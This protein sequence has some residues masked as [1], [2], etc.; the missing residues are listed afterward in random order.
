MLQCGYIDPDNGQGMGWT[1]VC[2][3]WGCNKA[4]LEV[5]PHR[6][7]PAGLWTCP[8]CHASYGD[9]A[10]VGPRCEEPAE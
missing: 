7:F 1:D 5:R 8:S 3:K 4:R 10:L 2:L 9:A 6:G